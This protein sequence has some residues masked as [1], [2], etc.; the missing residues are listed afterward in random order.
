MED[1]NNSRKR[2]RVTSTPSAGKVDIELD[3]SMDGETIAKRLKIP[4]R[5]N[6]ALNHLLRITSSHEI[7]YCLDGDTV[8]QSLVQTFFEVLGWDKDRQ[9]MTI[10]QIE[11][12]TVNVTGNYF[13]FFFLVKNSY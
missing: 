6:E 12:T 4:S 1:G 5:R 7:N 9:E 13:N 8:V 10:P 2:S 3:M 11:T